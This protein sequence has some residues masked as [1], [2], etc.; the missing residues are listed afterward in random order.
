MPTWPP[1]TLRCSLGGSSET[2]ASDREGRGS[3]TFIRPVW[4]KRDENGEK[5]GNIRNQAAARTFLKSRHIPS[6]PV[7]V[8]RRQQQPS[9]R[10]RA[11][12]SGAEGKLRSGGDSD[13]GGRD[14]R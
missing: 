3:V 14:A 2:P 6:R 11:G 9:S 7:A 8:A 10:A 5:A 13:E 1:E 4:G 12:E